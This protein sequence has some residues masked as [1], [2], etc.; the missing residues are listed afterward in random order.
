MSLKDL[1]QQQSQEPIAVGIDELQKEKERAER[2]SIPLKLDSFQQVIPLMYLTGET[3][4]KDNPQ[5]AEMIDGT[6]EDQVKASELRSKNVINVVNTISVNFD[7]DEVEAYNKA[8]PEGATRLSSWYKFL[9]PPTTKNAE[10]AKEPEMAKYDPVLWFFQNFRK[11]NLPVNFGYAYKSTTKRQWPQFQQGIYMMVW[12]LMEGELRYITPSIAQIIGLTDSFYRVPCQIRTVQRPASKAKVIEFKTLKIDADNHKMPED[13]STISGDLA[14]L[15]GNNFGREAIN[16][17]MITDL[18][19]PLNC[20]YYN[21][22][23]SSRRYF[24]DLLGL[25]ASYPKD[26]DWAGAQYN[27]E[28]DD[29][30]T[31]EEET[32]E[33][34]I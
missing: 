31:D 19:N 16:Y 3:F 2:Q 22:I 29:V 9:L 8:L 10:A 21:R 25:Q 23:A 26:A 15:V 13:I 11:L 7:K 30:E 32:G 34:I 1:L 6:Y 24:M 33:D 18:D 4:A 14:K 27:F 28:A 12:E 17:S 5:Y 20:P